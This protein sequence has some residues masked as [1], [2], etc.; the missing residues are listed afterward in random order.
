MRRAPSCY[1]VSSLAAPAA[2]VVFFNRRLC[3]RRTFAILAQVPP[4]KS[5]L[6]LSHRFAFVVHRHRVTRDVE[7]DVSCEPHAVPL[8]LAVRVAVF[9]ETIEDAIVPGAF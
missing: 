1:P 9:D 4:V 3:G 8:R 5:P 2:L 6:N 7:T